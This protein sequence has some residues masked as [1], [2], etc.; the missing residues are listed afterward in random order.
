MSSERSI[1]RRLFRSPTAHQATKWLTLLVVCGAINCLIPKI[2]SAAETNSKRVIFLHSFGPLFK[3]WSDYGRTIRAEIAHRSPWQIDFSDFSLVDARSTDKQSEAPLIRYLRALYASQ[4]PDLIIA[5]GAPAASFVQRHRSE[6]FYTTPMIFTAVDQ[7]LVNYG[8][9]SENDTVVPVTH[10]FAA[11]F[12]TILHVLPDTKLIAIVNGASPNE[13][14]WH[15]EIQREVSVLENRVAL[16]WYDEL[17]FADILKDAAKL[18]PH[19]AIF[20][21]LMNV[22]AAGIV[23]E[24]ND[25][26]NALASVA[27]APIFS[28][29]DS[30]F[31][32]A[33]VGGLMFSVVESS[34][35]TAK[36]AVR[37][38]SGEKAGDIKT[39]AI[40]FAPP[41]FDWRQMKRWGI[42]ESAL[43]PGSTIYF[44]PP[45]FWDVYRWYI[46]LG[47]TTIFL[48][49]FLISGLV[50]ERHRRSYAE[51]ELHQRMTEL[52]HV[53]RYS[54]AGELTA[55]IA[56]EINQPLGSILVNAESAD[57]ILGSPNP[58][59]DEL[60]KILLDIRR[61]DHRATEVIRRLRSLLK[62]APLEARLI[63]LNEPVREAIGLLLPTAKSLKIEIHLHLSVAPLQ[64]SADTIQIQQAVMNL[65]R[66]GFD[67]I[68]EHSAT[69]RS[70]FIST[71]RDGEEAMVSVS[72]TGG[73]I[74]VDNSDLIFN[75]FFST[76][77]DGMGMGLPIVQT[78]VDAHGGRVLAE[79]DR[80][81]AIF[82]IYLPLFTN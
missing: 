81:G 59:L 63:D 12:R 44:R 28:Y 37:I 33:L 23:H 38:L 76:K 43:P 69:N 8:L 66:N 64:V 57:L 75:P 68:C 55:T 50:W 39:P 24:A 2:S 32:G 19:S 4:P 48:Q 72:D 18:P 16:K 21:H 5:I 22:D 47:S 61:D 58:N 27:S 34:S 46:I 35:A 20:W 26:L 70:V 25:S 65:V 49:G 73:G 79:N 74:S 30:F 13:R 14:F 17:P 60:K 67:E 62:K 42:A 15:G 52:A 9:L 77:K 53:N 82:R 45:R 40:N 54:M 1:T 71:A 6:L 3:P 36:V 51:A 10:D 41:R 7:R 31:E 11:A 78:I 29:D 56:H 80:E